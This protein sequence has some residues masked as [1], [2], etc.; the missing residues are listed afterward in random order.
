MTRAGLVRS[1]LSLSESSILGLH[2]GPLLWMGWN[3][4]GMASAFISPDPALTAPADAA[5]PLPGF[6]STVP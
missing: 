3:W 5:G 1:V 2:P 4:I 6:S